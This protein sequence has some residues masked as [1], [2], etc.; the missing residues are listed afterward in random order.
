MEVHVHD[1]NKEFTN[2]KYT[3][4]LIRLFGDFLGISRVCADIVISI[5]GFGK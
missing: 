3:P 1:M 4:L 5:S 2:T